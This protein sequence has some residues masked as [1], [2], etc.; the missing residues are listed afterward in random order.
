MKNYSYLLAV[1]CSL[2]LVSCHW[3][4]VSSHT[5]PDSVGKM[6]YVLEE[7]EQEVEIYKLHG[8]EYARVR[9]C[10]SPAPAELYCYS[11]G[12]DSS[13]VVHVGQTEV[14]ACTPGMEKREFFITLDD[15]PA[16]EVVLAPESFAGL[17]PVRT[18]RVAPRELGVRAQLPSVRGAA[19][20]LMMPITGA[21][22]AADVGLSAV[23]TVGTYVLFNIPALVV[24]PVIA[25]FC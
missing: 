15:V 10:K 21:L 16:G 13:Y 8:V 23:A 22:L 4:K 3:V 14:P 2:F 1:F 9:G 20:Y 25:C 24:V 12:V 7:A 5:Y 17:K 19:N 6:I 11:W 18:Q